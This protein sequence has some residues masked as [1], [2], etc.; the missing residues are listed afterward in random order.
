MKLATH[1]AWHDAIVFAVQHEERYSQRAD[2]LIVPESVWE[3]AP[4]RKIRI[5]M[6]SHIPG[7]G[8]GA[9]RDEARRLMVS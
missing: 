3:E 1:S 6:S 5:E 9:F 7:A 4:D 2:S 8:E